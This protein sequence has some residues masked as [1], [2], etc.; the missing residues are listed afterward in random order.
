MLGEQE[1]EA[2]R[3]A[4]FDQALAGVLRGLPATAGDVDE[5]LSRAGAMES[6]VPA[7]DLAALLAA[8]GEH[9][10]GAAYGASVLPVTEISAGGDDVLYGLDTEAAAEVIR[11][12]FAEARRQGA[13][14][15]ARV[16]VQ[17]GVGTP[18]LA[19]RARDRLVDAGFRFV[20]G[21]N[22]STLGR[23]ESAVLVPRDR[24]DQREL[25]TAVAEALGLPEEVIAVGREAPT[26]ADVVV[27]LGADFAADAA[28][29]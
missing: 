6:T 20:A 15:A 14:E 13:G 3:L 18:G 5:V 10:R 7:G 4:R 24:P 17:N 19:D 21:G 12:R 23:Q 29:P 28:T 9:V 11:T 26:S 8:A 2:A 25:A 27:I 16:L 1:A 22:A